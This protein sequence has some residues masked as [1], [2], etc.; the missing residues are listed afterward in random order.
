MTAC[1][2][3]CGVATVHAYE[4]FNYPTAGTWNGGSSSGVG[5]SGNW[6]VA[7]STDASIGE[8]RATLLAAT[9]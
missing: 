7:N 2:A 4:G 3:N 6:T 5:F 9:P 1:P 8:R